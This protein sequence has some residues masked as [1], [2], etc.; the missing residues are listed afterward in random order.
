MELFVTDL[1]GTLLNKKSIVSDKSR[2]ILNPLIESG[3]QFTVATAR[4]HATV[5]D[6]L[7]GLAITLPIAVMNGV[8][9]YDLK[10]RK[11]LEI[12]SIED[13]DV[14]KCLTLMK[15]ANVS[16]LVYN[17][18]QN[19][20]FV[21]FENIAN[22]ATNQF[23]QSRQDKT[24]KKFKQVPNLFDTLG[25][26]E[27]VNMLVFDKTDVVNQ[28]AAA[29]NQLDAITVTAYEL[30]NQSGYSYLELYSSKASKAN[31]IKALL[32]YVTY[33][34][35]VV[36]GDNL[37]DIPMFELADESYATSNGVTS[38]KEIATNVIGHHDEEA[39]AQYVADRVAKSLQAK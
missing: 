23:Y 37:N 15:D 22:E 27:F 21:Y 39:V 12:V 11:Y 13:Q 33:D 10:Q 32:K 9:I 36:F 6:L 1:D 25:T 30:E 3:L 7:D 17:I 29:L 4:T 8:G 24:L 2:E 38:L 34:Q 19:E 28:L 14:E 5:I 31:G 26:G 35:L 16:P 20:L 18:H